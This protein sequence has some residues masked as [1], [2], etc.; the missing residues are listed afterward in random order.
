MTV[1]EM[2]LVE[3]DIGVDSP[4]SPTEPLPPI[5]KIPRG[6]AVVITGRAPV[7]RYAMAVHE[8]HGSP[9]AVVATFDP[10]LGAVI[11]MSHHPAYKPGDII[12]I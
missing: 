8:L 11:V 12:E 1:I 3:Y 2:D 5:P 6:S 10:R 9:A 4:I 7:W